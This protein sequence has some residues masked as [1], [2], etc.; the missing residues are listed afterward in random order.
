MS[1]QEDDD[2]LDRLARDVA[3]PR[4][5]DGVEG[6]VVLGDVADAGQLLGHLLDQGLLLVR[7]AGAWTS[8]FVLPG[9]AVGE[10]VTVGL[11]EAGADLA[12]VGGHGLH[13]RRGGD[14]PHRAA[15]EVDAEVE[16][17]GRRGRPGRWR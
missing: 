5:P 4:W 2:G 8:M 9:L 14:L 13:R 17:P 15:L 1:D 16:A 10:M 6:D 3:P 12:Q 11:A 7:V